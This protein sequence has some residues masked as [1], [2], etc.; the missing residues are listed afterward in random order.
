MMSPGAPFGSLAMILQAA[1]EKEKKRGK[2]SGCSHRLVD[3]IYFRLM[4]WYFFPNPV[5]DFFM[6][7]IFIETTFL[8][9]QL[10]N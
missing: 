10:H 5:L 3:F 4:C 9:L 6:I 7:I 8:L 1:K 2:K